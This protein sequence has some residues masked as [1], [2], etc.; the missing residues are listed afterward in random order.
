MPFTFRLLIP[1]SQ[2]QIPLP[3]P[4][5]R[6]RQFTVFHERCAM[7][8]TTDA[9]LF[10]AWCAGEITT[11]TP[12][13]GG[14]TK[15]TNDAP[16]EPETINHK[17]ETLLDIGTGT[18]LLSLMVRQKNKVAIDAVEIDAEAA[19]Q[20]AENVDASGFG[21]IRVLHQDLRSFN[22]GKAYD[23]IISN[24]PFYEDDLTSGKAR[25]DTAHH[26]GN[27][28]LDEL[29]LF[30]RRHLSPNGS[31]FLL[32]PFKRQAELAQKLLSHNL[33]IFHKIT[34]RQSTRHQPFRLMLRCAPSPVDRSIENE[35][36][37]RDE[38]DNYSEEFVGLLKDYYLYL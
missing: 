32:M 3:N 27:L 12:G 35:I 19:A 21:G 14:F 16:D 20:A 33:F 30:V 13:H 6:F 17:P 34:V 26:S 22:P 37:I 15:E 24:P 11:K 4:Y 10:G 36:S 2:Y 18:G 9:C 38:A 7:K 1:N 25:K 23:F 8:V 5:F 28:K 31:F 29:L